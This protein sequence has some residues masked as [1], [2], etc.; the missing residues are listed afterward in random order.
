VL[1]ALASADALAVIPVGTA[2][3]PAGSTVE[4]EMF[5]YPEDRGLS[6]P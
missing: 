6:G 2:D 4:L 3:V 5:R 1:S